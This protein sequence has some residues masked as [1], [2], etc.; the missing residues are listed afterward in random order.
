MMITRLPFALM[1]DV[2]S[3][4]SRTRLEGFKYS[5][6]EMDAVE[7]TAGHRQLAGH[8]GAARQDKRVELGA[9]FRRRPYPHVGSAGGSKAPLLPR[10]DC[11][12]SV[13]R[14]P[15]PSLGARSGPLRAPPDG[16]RT[17][18]GHT[19]GLQ[20]GQPAIEH[21]LLHLEFRDA[22]AQEP[23]GSLRS[24]EHGDGVAGPCQLLG[25]RQAGRAR[26]D[27]GDR[28]A[29]AHR[30]RLRGHPALG[31]GALHDLVLD[32]LNG[33]RVLVDPEDAGGLARSRAQSA[34][35]LGKVV[36]RVQPLH[37]VGPVVAV[38]EVVP[39][40]DQVPEWAA[41]VAE[42]DAAV[43]AARALFLHRLFGK[44]LVDLAPVAQAHGNGAAPRQRTAVLHEA[45]RLTHLRPP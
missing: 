12:A 32:P 28:L 8:G 3:A 18:E 39:L 31:P 11:L 4:P 26:A 29:G 20:L 13:T 23:A 34:G 10:L 43:H 19:L 21:R 42:R 15:S 17:H 9:H 36:R 30:R 16:G 24:L 6:R 37:G 5:E 27:D 33:D 1:G 45:G 7:V 2:R 25:D 22:V 44:R 40:G 38:D 35:E 41:V 14:G